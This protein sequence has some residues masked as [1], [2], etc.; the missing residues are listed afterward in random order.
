M[1]I[2]NQLSSSQK[3]RSEQGNRNVA[4]LILDNPQLIHEIIACL[5]SKNK[6]LLGDCVEVCTML[7][8]DEPELIAP[9]SDQFFPLLNHKNT[10]VRWE[11]MH[12][13][14]LITPYIPDSVVNHWNQLAHQFEH[15]KSVIVRDYMVVCAGNLAASEASTASKVY[16]FLIDAL[17]AY[18]THHAKLALEGLAKGLANL[19]ANWQEIAELADLYI[20][21]PKPSIRKAA[22]QLQQRF[23][24]FE[25]EV[26][27]IDDKFQD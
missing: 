13:V 3:Q 27:I 2:I 7:A 22:R 14:A 5:Q 6:A 26:P 21:H 10:R 24:S 18:Q 9:Y 11:A 4:A 20:Q 1:S 12:A 16:P 8:A 15:E 23:S 25:A 19:K 17:N